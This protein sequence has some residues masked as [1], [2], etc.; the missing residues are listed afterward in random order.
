MKRLL[1]LPAAAL[2]RIRDAAATG[3]GWIELMVVP[4]S[5]EEAAVLVGMALLAGGFLVAGVPALALLVPG[6]LYVAIGLGF[7]LRRGR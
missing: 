1:A 5:G 6:T 3:V 2:E 7:N 4:E